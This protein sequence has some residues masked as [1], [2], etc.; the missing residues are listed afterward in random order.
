MLTLHLNLEKSRVAQMYSNY[1]TCSH[2][3]WTKSS[4]DQKCKSHHSWKISYDLLYRGRRLLCTRRL[5]KIYI[6]R[7]SLSNEL[8]SFKSLVFSG[9]LALFTDRSSDRQPMGIRP[10]LMT[11]VFQKHNYIIYLYVEVVWPDD[12][13]FDNIISNKFHFF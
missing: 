13:Y 7:L 11:G 8:Q 5:N 10:L 2:Q 6:L 1:K 9:V 12:A 3:S 4:N